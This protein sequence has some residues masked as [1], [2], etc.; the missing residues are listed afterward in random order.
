MGVVTEARSLVAEN[1]HKVFERVALGLAPADAG[2]AASR[3]AFQSMMETLGV[4][5]IESRR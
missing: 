4:F 5:D 2:M 3:L 1:D